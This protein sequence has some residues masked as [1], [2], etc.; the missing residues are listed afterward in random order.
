MGISI[1][2]LI[3]SFHHFRASTEEEKQKVHALILSLLSIDENGRFFVPN[4]ATLPGAVVDEVKF[5]QTHLFFVFRFFFFLCIMQPNHFFY[6]WLCIRSERVSSSD[7][8]QAGL[9]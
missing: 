6:L 7:H 3:W 4:P 8:V 2:F 1:A 5:S 9:C